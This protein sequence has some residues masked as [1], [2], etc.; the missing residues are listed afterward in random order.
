MRQIISACLLSALL[1]AGV[2]CK[3][4]SGIE[5]HHVKFAGVKQIDADDLRA[6]L[7]TQPSSRLPWG[8]KNHFD[9]AKFEADLKRIQAF[10]LDR[11][12]PDA[13]VTSFDVA[14]N[15]A[16]T[17][18]DITID[19]A[20]GQP[21]TASAVTFNG[22][23]ALPARARQ[24]LEGNAP[25]KKGARLDRSWLNT[26]REMAL[27]ALR[28]N[29]Y[30]YAKVT[31][32]QQPGADPK[33]VAVSYTAAPGVLA[34]FGPIQ[35][36]G[37]KSVDDNIITRQLRYKP[38]D[39]YRRNVMLWSQRKLYDLELFQF[40]NIQNLNAEQQPAEVPTRVTVA[41]SKHQHVQFAGG[42]GTEEK[43][44]AEAQWH[45]VNFLGGARQFGVRAKWS[46]LDR[47][48]RTEFTQPYFFGSNFSLGL[49][50]HQWYQDQPAFTTRSSGGRVSLN[51]RLGTRSSLSFSLIDEYDSSTVSPEALA[52]PTIRNQLIALGL[53]PETGEQ[54][55]TLNA[56]SVDFLQHT[57]ANPLNARTG[58]YVSAHLE[59]AGHWVRG[60]YGYTAIAGE[61][62]RYFPVTRATVFAVRLRY[63]T[64]R[65]QGNDAAEIPFFK[66]MFL[67][68]ADSLRGW[69]LY[70][71][72]PLSGEGLPVG[73]FTTFVGSGELRRAITSKLGV[74]AFL[75]FGNVWADAWA[76]HPHDLRY[77]VGPGLRYDT[78][79]GPF[80][81]DLGYQLNPIPG[82]Q[83]NG[84]PET[85][86]WRVHFSI[87][88][89][90]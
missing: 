57:A 83:V 11:G 24:A 66:R 1:L 76:I 59:Q 25:I 64:I 35:V 69:G 45:D 70:E 60:T 27:N 37:N 8:K 38:G 58:Y 77:D 40:A 75:D 20:E 85:R 62:R 53:D 21:V 82:L 15:K 51:Q 39:L 71:V 9:R 43:V 87:G 29:G 26:T 36:L 6:A 42:Y 86:R 74:V 22:F 41:E 52:D 68:G 7:A 89:A 32:Q 28:D 2:G 44:R 56:V 47:G 73:G 30:P 81:I 50:G 19:I 55:G 90:F 13:R 16:Q 34:H 49:E 88:Q 4:I 84:K 5:V 14:L 79:V 17:A 54:A 3:D 67:G 48:V 23:D 61:G 31:L 63:G 72:S 46:S 10:Y 18:V 78:P 65:P 80:R 12:F 33:Q